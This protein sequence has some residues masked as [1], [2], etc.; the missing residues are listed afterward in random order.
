MFKNQ[1]T[2]CIDIRNI[3]EIVAEFT[4]KEKTIF[5]PLFSGFAPFQKNEK[6]VKPENKGAKPENKGAKPENKGAKPENKGGKT[7]F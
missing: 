6:G 1:Q 2:N 5:P 4:Q 7:C 3:H